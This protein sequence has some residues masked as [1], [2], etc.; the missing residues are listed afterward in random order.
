M[1][2]SNNGPISYRFWDRR[3]FPSKIAKFSHLVVFYTPTEG[4]PL[5]LG[6]GAWDQKTTVVAIGPRKKFDDT[7][8]H[9]DTIHQRDG[10]TG[11][12]T[13]GWTLGHS[14]NYAYA[15]RRVV[16]TLSH[17]SS[18][19]FRDIWHI[20]SYVN[21]YWKILLKAV[22]SYQSFHMLYNKFF[23]NNNVNVLPLQ[24][25]NTV[26]WPTWPV[27]RNTSPMQT[28]WHIPKYYL[29]KWRRRMVATNRWRG[30]QLCSTVRLMSIVFAP[31]AI[32]IESFG[33]SDCN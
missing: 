14:K 32:T 7:F 8:S 9:M 16:K 13:N 20:K 6:I 25:F 15:Q 29:E 12:L 28:H 1:F 10:Q 33:I 5:E 17:H 24:H 4:F 3:R 30:R 11:G 22:I 18:Q 26:G 31:S 2:H 19:I 23:K 27:S 21:F